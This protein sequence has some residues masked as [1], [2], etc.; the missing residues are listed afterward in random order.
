MHAK[1]HSRRAC[2][3][4]GSRPNRPLKTGSGWPRWAA[5]RPERPPVS[6]SAKPLDRLVPP[7]AGM[8][9][10]R[11]VP[12]RARVLYETK[13]S[14]KAAHGTVS[15]ASIA[16]R[17]VERLER[18]HHVLQIG[19][20]IDVNDRDEANDAFFIND[21]QGPLGRPR[22]CAARQ[23]AWRPRRGAR[24]P[25]TPETRVHPFGRSRHARSAGCQR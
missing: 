6:A 25:T 15:A 16:A 14:R 23:T 22:R 13:M 4:T 9:P 18:I 1:N 7:D 21:E 20:P 24:N 19:T 10:P 12:D 2:N 8:R 17:V 3:G 11:R 5:R